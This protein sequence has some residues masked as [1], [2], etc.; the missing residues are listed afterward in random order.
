MFD[1][2]KRSKKKLLGLTSALEL[3]TTSENLKYEF[4]LNTAEKLKSELRHKHAPLTCAEKVRIIK[5][6][7]RAK[8][9]AYLG[10]RRDDYKAYRALNNISHDLVQML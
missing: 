10:G 1:E 5:S 6:V 8:A 3:G 7:T 4:M 2:Y 9:K